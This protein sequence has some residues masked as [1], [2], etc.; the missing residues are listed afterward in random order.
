M[1]LCMALNGI[2]RV[3]SRSTQQTMTLTGSNELTCRSDPQ[4]YI[5]NMDYV[6]CGIA[7]RKQLYKVRNVPTHSHQQ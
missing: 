6:L 7:V 1:A 4:I 2:E 5:I 3:Y